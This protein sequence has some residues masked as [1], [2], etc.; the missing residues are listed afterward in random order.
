MAFVFAPSAT[1]LKR[2]LSARCGTRPESERQPGDF[3][4]SPSV[5]HTEARYWS[6]IVPKNGSCVLTRGLP[7]VLATPAPQR[8]P[9]LKRDIA[10][11]VHEAAIRLL[12]REGNLLLGWTAQRIEASFQPSVRNAVLNLV[13]RRRPRRADP[14]GEQL[15]PDHLEPDG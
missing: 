6:A 10:P 5:G 11:L 3:S 9:Y 8:F 2:R 7:E 4:E 12:V 14:P 13:E 15:D 1:L